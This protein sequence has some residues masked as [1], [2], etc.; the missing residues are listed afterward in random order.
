[1]LNFKH[2]SPQVSLRDIQDVERRF[3]FEFPAAL[4]DLYLHN[5]G[6]RPDRD[7]VYNDGGMYIVDTVFGIK[8]AA[9]GNSLEFHIQSVKVDQ[10]LLPEF[11][12][13][14]GMN[15]GGDYFCFSTR[16]CDKGEIFIFRMD[17][18]KDPDRGTV[19]LASSPEEF[20]KML[21]KKPGATSGTPT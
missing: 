5:N 17:F 8:S 3:G 12:V 18:Y 6:G 19:R 11:L 20:L 16:D 15:P 10:P 2:S 4:R 9:R 7:R 21:T 1:M 14:F 13:P